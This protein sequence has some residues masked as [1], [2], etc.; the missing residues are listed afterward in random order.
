MSR[1]ETITTAARRFVDSVDLSDPANAARAALIRSLATQVKDA[2]G[3]EIPSVVRA[4]PQMAKQLAD[5]ITELESATTPP[6][7]EPED[8]F[9]AWLLSP[10][11]TVADD[12]IQAFGFD[13]AEARW[14]RHEAPRNPPVTGPDGRRWVSTWEWRVP[15]P[16]PAAVPANEI[17]EDY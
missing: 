14:L 15:D 4:V 10:M 16:A 1:P 8:R 2:E 5:A 3:S 9:L 6:V 17:P 12:V 11:A 13:E 7:P